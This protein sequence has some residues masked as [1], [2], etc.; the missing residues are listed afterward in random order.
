MSMDI[1]D[2]LDEILI[3]DLREH[4]FLSL[5]EIKKHPGLLPMRVNEFFLKT[6]MKRMIYFRNIYQ[7]W[8]HHDEDPNLFK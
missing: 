7:A 5:E 3:A 2:R 6:F 4:V 8:K 1:M